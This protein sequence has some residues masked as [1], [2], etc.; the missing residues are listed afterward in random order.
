MYCVPD[1]HNPTGLVMS[2][3]C[4][5]RLVEIAR[6]CG[7]ALIVDETLAETTIDAE[8]P[9]PIAVHAREGAALM[10]IGSLSKIFW[11]GLRVGWMR[12]PEALIAKAAAIK[13]SLD[14]ATPVFDQ[15]MALG[16]FNELPALMQ[17]RRELLR[18][19]RDH[20]ITNLSA[21]IPEWRVA[22]PKGGLSAWIDLGI[23][24][25]SRLADAARQELVAITPGTLFGSDG[26]FED[27]IRIPFTLETPLASEAVR[28]LAKA[29]SA[30]RE[31]RQQTVRPTA[32]VAV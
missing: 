19:N 29:W 23:P 12:A 22:P 13:A 31:N 9:V 7:S 2:E 3:E 15:L 8:A 16:V 14:M 32:T 28:R 11:G 25:A 21:L 24:V 6:L 5:A 10:T 1:F 30:V 17:E 18:R 27:R 4:R 26:S 20:L